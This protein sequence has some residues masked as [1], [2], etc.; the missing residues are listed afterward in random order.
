[1]KWF[2]RYNICFH[3][4]LILNLIGLEFCNWVGFF[5]IFLHCR[6]IKQGNPIEIN[7]KKLLKGDGNIAG[8]IPF[9]GAMLLY[10]ISS[11]RYFLTWSRLYNPGPEAR[12]D[13]KKKTSEYLPAIRRATQ[14][15]VVRAFRLTAYTLQIAISLI[16]WLNI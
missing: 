12:L 7:R 16:F 9:S 3:L 4:T 8:H 1:M 15:N 6:E 10:Y 14:S 11:Y 13:M 5:I 2:C